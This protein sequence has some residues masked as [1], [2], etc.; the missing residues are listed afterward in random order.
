MCMIKETKKCPCCGSGNFEEGDYQVCNVCGWENDP[1]QEKYP[2]M[3]GGA[4][5][6]SLQ[7][8]RKRWQEQK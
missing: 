8:C 5:E 1:V 6:E 4:N 7:G 3:T 2:D